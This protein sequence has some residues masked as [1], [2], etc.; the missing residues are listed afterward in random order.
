MTPMPTCV[1]CV[2]TEAA[3]S[4]VTPAPRPTMCAAWQRGA[5]GLAAHPDGFA[6]S[7]A[8]EAEVGDAPLWLHTALLC[9]AA[10][11]RRCDLPS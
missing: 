5:T 8:W 1:C 3:C 7:A 6:Q 10:L 9:A 4:A 2:E 11:R